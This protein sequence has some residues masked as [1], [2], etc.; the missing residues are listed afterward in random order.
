MFEIII[1]PDSLQIS[2][3]DAEE[4]CIVQN[5]PHL[6]KLLCLHV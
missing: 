4:N 2:I 5:F 1:T 3:D 6:Q